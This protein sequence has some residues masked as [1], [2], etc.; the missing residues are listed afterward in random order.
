MKI[1]GVGKLPVQT[2]GEEMPLGGLAGT[3]DAHH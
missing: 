2:L 3:G 1:V